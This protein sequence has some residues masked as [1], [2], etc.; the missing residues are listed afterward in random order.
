MA[1]SPD[2]LG[3]SEAV[4]LFLQRARAVNHTFAPDEDDLRTIAEL[5][6][7]LD[8]LPLA[9][10]L[11]A[12]RLKTLTPHAILARLPQQRQLLSSTRR[13]V[14][15][16]QR[17]LWATLTWSYDLLRSHEQALLRRLAIFVG[18]F[19]LDAAEAV[20]GAPSSDDEEPSPSSL[21]DGLATLVDHSLLQRIEP[22]GGEPRFGMLETV[23]AVCAGAAGGEC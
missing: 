23:R 22:S 13:D 14:P 3:K 16:R 12:A 1:R 20:A 21:I 8:G 10:E 15:D 6:R 4:A 9:I 17:T 5:C 11:A 19:T 2:D 7:Q 18:G